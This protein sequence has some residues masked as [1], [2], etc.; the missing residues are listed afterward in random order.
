MTEQLFLVFSAPAVVSAQEC[1][2][3][4]SQSRQAN[5][6][7]D[8]A[9]FALRHVAIGIYDSTRH[10]MTEYTALRLRGV[11]QR[12]R[13]Y[14]SVSDSKRRQY[15]FMRFKS[16]DEDELRRVRFFLS[17]QIGRPYNWI[18][19]VL[20]FWKCLCCVQACCPVGVTRRDVRELLVYRELA[21]R[22]EEE[23]EKEGDEEEDEEEHEMEEVTSLAHTS[24]SRQPGALVMSNAWTCSE[25]C[26]VTLLYAGLFNLS[27]FSTQPCAI[28]PDELFDLCDGRCERV[29][30]KDLIFVTQETHK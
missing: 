3:L 11:V 27:D 17:H 12:E 6:A 22:E 15:F 2:C 28:T 10:I 13:Q 26:L 18:G 7:R 8:E 1:D 14:A 21:E 19:S 20:N 16:V 5:R 23:E 29:K 9:N 4:S 30:Q 25:L 24:Q